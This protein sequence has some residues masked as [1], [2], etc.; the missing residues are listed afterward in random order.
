MKALTLV[1]LIS[2]IALGQ[3]GPD[4]LAKQKAE[5]AARL[6]RLGKASSVWWLFIH[7]PDPSTRSYLI[8]ELA[9]ANVNP[10]LIIRRLDNEKDVSARRALILSLGEFTDEQLSITKRKPLVTK[11]LKWYQSDPDPG[12]HAS[13]D[14]LLRYGLQGER[15]RKL[16]WQQSLALARIDEQLTGTAPQKRNWY[17]SKAGHTMVIVRGPAGWF[18]MGSPAPEIGRIPASDSPDEPLQ[19]VRIVRSFA[20]AS[21]E[22]TVA[23]FRRFL[24]AKPDVKSR[25]AYA[26]N[27]NRMSEVMQQFSPDDAGPQ[28]AVTWYEAAMYCN[29]LSQQDGL[30]ESEWVYP[31]SFE[32][33]KNGMQL[34]K[35]YLHRIGYRLPTEAE[36]EYAAR[37]GSLTARFYGNSDSL[38]KEYAWYSAN[39]PKHKND[40]PDP[41]D[42][43]RTWPVGQLKPNDLGLFDVYGNVWE[44]TQDRVEQYHA[45]EVRDDVEDKV[46]SVSDSEARARRG[47]GFPYEAAMMRSAARGTKTAFPMLR[48]DN[49]GFRVARTYR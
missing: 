12:I 19:Q 48:R 2:S 24:E 27:P 15:A 30:P 3:V 32:E 22:V 26:G 8:H 1:V 5:D 31:K 10:S 29:W 23:Q 18:R 42:P 37:A 21:K 34:P 45:S 40:A 39:P 41:R 20:I 46:L 11:L 38:L 9:R 17:V 25:H 49:V 47:G 43:R 35:D 6:L 14:W 44:W 16:D 33:F 28:I 13:I 7:T 36:W 4:Q